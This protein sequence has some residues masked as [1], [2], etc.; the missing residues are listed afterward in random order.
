MKLDFFFVYFSGLAFIHANAEKLL[1]EK[2]NPCPRW[3]AI[4]FPA[5]VE[6]AR[7]VGIEMIFTDRLEAMVEEIFDQ[8]QQ[9]LNT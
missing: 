9:I 2:Y 1:E 7:S 3:F 8:R 6:L 4:V 5:M